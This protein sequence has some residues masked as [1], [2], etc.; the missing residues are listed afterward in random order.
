MRRISLQAARISLLTPRNSLQAARRLLQ[1]A[2]TIVARVCKYR[3]VRILHFLTSQGAPGS[4]R[5]RRYDERPPICR[6]NPRAGGYPTDSI[7]EGSLRAMRSSERSEEAGTPE[8]SPPRRAQRVR[9]EQWRS[10]ERPE[11][12]G[13]AK[14]SAPRRARRPSA[15]ARG[16]EGPRERPTGGEQRRDRRSRRSPE[17]AGGI[18]CDPY[19]QQGVLKKAVRP[20]LPGGSQPA[21][22]AES[23]KLEL[24]F[25]DRQA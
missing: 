19:H 16:S 1:E 20:W 14:R 12:P 23:A 21:W 6:G 17:G 9:R 7:A 5:S 2:S 4:S 13:T 24:R 22:L 25:S 8:G 11:G 18:L 15:S 10:G 3:L